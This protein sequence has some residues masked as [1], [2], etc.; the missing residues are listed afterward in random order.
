MTTAQRI[1]VVCGVVSIASIA[2]I[3]IVLVGVVKGI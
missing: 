2:G 3:A 1:V